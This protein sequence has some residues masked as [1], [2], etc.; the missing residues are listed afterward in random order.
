MR[1][2]PS[3]DPPPCGGARRRDVLLA[4]I[5]GALIRFVRLILV[6][7]GCSADARAGKIRQQ[8]G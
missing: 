1:A 3:F 6:W 8:H 4:A 2:A 5:R 7:P